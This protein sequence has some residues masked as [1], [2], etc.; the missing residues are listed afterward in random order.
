MVLQR[1]MIERRPRTIWID[2]GVGR[3]R[4]WANLDKK[5]R[6]GIGRA[7]REGAVVEETRSDADLEAFFQLCIGVSRAKEFRLPA[8]LNLMRTLLDG[9]TAGGTGAHLFVARIGTAVAAGAFIL[10]CGTSIHYMWGATDRS[11][12]K[13]ALGEATQW[14]VLEWA[15]DRGIERFDLEGIDPRNNPG[16]YAFKKKLGGEEIVLR[17]R[18]A[19]SL[20]M[21]GRVVRRVLSM[22]QSDR[23]G[24][25]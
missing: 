14:A 11:A 4:L 21:R 13:L 6:W 8:S 2:V 9:S 3:D 18:R 20:G 10:R 22:L 1:A 23:L 24:I 15:A 12:P 25:G 16:V 17:G 5:V 19:Q 7:R